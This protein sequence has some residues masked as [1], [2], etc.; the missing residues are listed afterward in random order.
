MKLYSSNSIEITLEKY[1]P[2]DIVFPP[3][4]AV[5]SVIDNLDNLFD[6]SVFGSTILKIYLDI[7]SAIV[8][9]V[10]LNE[11]ITLNCN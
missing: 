4:H 3:M 2:N 5:A 7:S 10:V 8:N 9:S 11:D 1:L 6:F